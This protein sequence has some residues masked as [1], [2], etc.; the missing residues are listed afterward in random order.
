VYSQCLLRTQVAQFKGILSAI[1]ENC[2]G[3]FDGFM[4]ALSD[5]RKK[6]LG[7]TSEVWK[8][9]SGRSK[10]LSGNYV[11]FEGDIKGKQDA[12]WHCYVK[13]EGDIKGKQIVKFEETSKVHRKKSF[14]LF[15]FKQRK[16]R[17]SGEN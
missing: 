11:K 10:S 6:V 5:T 12:L 8:K 4:R 14:S 16:I 7:F 15:F 1:T 9:F 17:S 13:F 3:A 2:V